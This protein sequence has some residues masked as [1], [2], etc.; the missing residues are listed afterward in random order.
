MQP[1]GGGAGFPR[2]HEGA[3]ALGVCRDPHAR[4]RSQVDHRVQEVR[5]PFAALALHTPPPSL[6]PL[7]LPL[8][9]AHATQRAHHHVYTPLRRTHTVQA[10][11]HAQT[12]AATAHA[13]V[14]PWP[15]IAHLF[16]ASSVR[17]HACSHISISIRVPTHACIR[18]RAHACR[19]RRVP[20]CQSSVAHR[21]RRD[22]R[23]T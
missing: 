18:M 21:R 19:Q 11:A 4:S 22:R 6:Y 1:G 5:R 12:A 20:P 14:T 10:R 9:R 3:V 23:G 17:I 15:N 16:R 13:N 7:P 8:E 2:R